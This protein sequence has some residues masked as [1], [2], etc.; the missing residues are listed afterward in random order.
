MHSTDPVSL[1][2]PRP[3]APVPQVI[4]AKGWIPV[5]NKL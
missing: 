2:T 5:K 3:S 4:L 1:F